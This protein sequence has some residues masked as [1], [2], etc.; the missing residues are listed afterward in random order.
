M[1]GIFT[2]QSDTFELKTNK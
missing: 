2:L 1:H